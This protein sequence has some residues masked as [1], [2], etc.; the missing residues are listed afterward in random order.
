ME[1]SKF[2]LFFILIFASSFGQNI[3]NPLIS[4]EKEVN[5]CIKENSEEE[6]DCYREYYRELQFWATEVFNAVFEIVSK[7]KTES[8]KKT[9]KQEQISW[10]ESTYWYYAKTMEEFQNKHPDK[11][12]WD[13][14]FKL[15]ADAKTFYLKNTK[16]YTDRISYLLSLVE[17]K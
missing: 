6:L 17:N 15:K 7:N 14:D 5:Q 4:L 16:Y 2:I 1:K 13:K 10:K 8:E 11:F 9:F 12:V 3:T